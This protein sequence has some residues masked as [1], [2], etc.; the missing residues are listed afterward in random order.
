MEIEYPKGTLVEI[1]VPAGSGAVHVSNLSIYH[2]RDYEGN[3]IT[4]IESEI[5]YY[6]SGG[7]GKPSGDIYVKIRS[8]ETLYSRTINDAVLVRTEF[9]PVDLPSLIQIKALTDV[10]KNRKIQNG[11]FSV[12]FTTLVPI[13]VQ[14]KKNEYYDG[15]DV[16]IKPMKKYL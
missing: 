12:E 16:I 15:H 7:S 3:P 8:P 10:A 1:S 6:P 5:R 4:A 2:T 13:I 9:V 11:Y 14:V